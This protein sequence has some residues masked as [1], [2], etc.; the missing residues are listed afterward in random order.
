MQVNSNS[1]DEIDLKELF[2]VFWSGKYFIMLI[3][4]LSLCLGSLY[5]RTLS[6]RYGVSIVLAPVLEDEEITNYGRL[7]NLASF[8]GINL[9]SSNSSDFSKYKLMLKTRETAARIVLETNLL[10]EIFNEE[11]DDTNQTWREPERTKFSMIKGSIKKILTGKTRKTYIP[12]NPARLTE[13]ISKNININFDKKTQYI[14]LD[15]QSTNP[16][17]L[18]EILLSIIYSTDQMF[19]EKFI[20]QTDNSIKFYQTKLANS[21]SQEHRQ[22][23]ATLIAKEERKLLLARRNGPFVAE[24][25]TGPNTSLNPISPIAS[26]VLALSILLGIILSSSII[27]LRYSFRKTN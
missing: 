4:L 21:Q 13:F 26:L 9:P 20:R 15:A 6:P 3:T 10:Q 2:S 5:F 24:I 27:L 1:N 17:L 14:N 22:I 8:A 11:W 19:K 7:G 25:L 23:L 12:P 16:K 18:S